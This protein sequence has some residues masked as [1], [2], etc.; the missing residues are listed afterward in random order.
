MQLRFARAMFVGQPLRMVKGNVLLCGLIVAVTPLLLFAEPQSSAFNSTGFPGAFDPRLCAPNEWQKLENAVVGIR[1][2]PQLVFERSIR[3]FLLLGGDVGWPNYPKPHPYDELALDLGSARWENWLPVGKEWGPRFGDCKPPGWKSEAWTLTDTEGNIRPTLVCY[4]FGKWYGM[5][6][7]APEQGITYFYV[8]GSTFAYDA[9]A[10]KWV[11][12]AP[13]NHPSRALGGLL[14]WGS[15]CWD[16]I[17]RAVVLFGGG[18]ITSPRGD[19]GT[20]MYFPASNAWVKLEFSSTALDGLREKCSAFF[21]RTKRLAEFLRA[22]YYRATLPEHRNL[23]VAKQILN[24]ADEAARLALEMKTA[25]GASPH[26]H[27]QLIWA[28]ESLETAQEA[29]RR[30]RVPIT[31]ESLAVADEARD[32]AG[33]ARDALS[34]EPP[35]RALSPLVF[36]AKAGKIIL[37]GGDRLDRLVADTW[38]FDCRTR[39]WYERRPNQSP[40]PR[41]GHAMV[42]LPKAGK[43]LLFGGFTYRPT[44]DYVGAQYA[45]LP[46]EM[47]V[48]DATVDEW[49]PLE[50]PADVKSVPGAGRPGLTFPCAADEN[51]LVVAL[52]Q[53]GGYTSVPATWVCTVDTKKVSRDRKGVPPRTITRRSGPFI[54]EFFDKAPPADEA[55]VAT[56]LRNLPPNSWIR[57]DPPVKPDTDRCW[58]TAAYSP[59]HDVIMHWSGGHSSHCGTEV[60]RYHPGLNRWSLATDSEMPLEY[61]YSNDGTP[62]QWSFSGRP[63]MTGHTYGSYGYDPALKRMIFAGKGTHTYFFDPESGDWDGHSA[64]NPFIGEFYTAEV[65]STPGGA[66]VWAKLIRDRVKTGLWQM[67][68]TSRRWKELPLD[69]TLP[70]VNADWHGGVYDSKRDRLLLF[71]WG[72]KGDVTAY[73]MRTG[74]A[75]LLNPIN[76]EKAAA[77]SRETVYMEHCDMV[78]IGAHVA[79]PDGTMVM[80]IYDCAKNMWLGVDLG[81]ANPV[82]SGGKRVGFNNSVGFVYDASRKLV[83]VLDQRSGVTVL[84]FVPNPQVIRQLN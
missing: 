7:Y 31:A 59:D 50:I 64:P 48:Y 18:N 27:R 55:D 26:E 20:W 44:T 34:L 19:P 2:N 43:T 73:D 25:H 53:V 46:F 79:A 30:I 12:L 71:S 69:G 10:R 60:I 52:E 13:A 51:D 28:Q 37:F 63:W 3:R 14:L 1:L 36:D 67:E 45:N 84:R 8:N 24:L 11:D 82:S 22:G 83:W 40:S 17:N 5:S 72:A 77:M 78:L 57:I 58:G 32:E 21:N 74:E 65:I 49:L 70:P 35:P 80:P 61:I 76:K 62:G 47:W 66:V 23:D 9:A 42:Y 75:K 54:P 6:A 15:L 29:L 33:R 68:A 41:A 38:V 39:R 81:G 16:S 56:R 4:P